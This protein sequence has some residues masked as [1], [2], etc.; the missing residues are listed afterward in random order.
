M[1]I[2]SPAPD[3]SER[4]KVFPDPEIVTSFCIVVGPETSR[5]PKME[6]SFPTFN[7]FAIVKFPPVPEGLDI[8]KF[9]SN[10]SSYNIN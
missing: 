9:I 10:W 6:A 1:A 2:L 5:S 7:S 4:T 8:V 3:K